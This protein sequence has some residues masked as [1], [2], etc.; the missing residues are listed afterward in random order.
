MTGQILQFLEK[1]PASGGRPHTGS[2]CRAWGVSPRSALSSTGSL[3]TTEA[4]ASSRWRL[5]FVCMVLALLAFYGRPLFAQDEHPPSQALAG[6][7]VAP[8]LEA[9][10]FASEPMMLSPT[11]IDVDARGRV[12]VCEV[13]NY[14]HRNGERPEGDRILILEDTDGDGRADKSTV[15]YQG[16]DIDSAMGI[17]VLGNRV[18][19]SVSPNVFV[20]TDTDGDGK[21]DKKELL[22]TKAGELQ[23][24]HTAHKFVFGPD[25]RLYWN[26]GNAEPSVYDRDGKVVKDIFGNPVIDGGHPFHGGMAFRCEP[27]GSR[28]EVLAHNFRNNY[29]LAVDSF[30]GL[31][32]SDND[33]DGN[34]AVRINYLL[35]YGNYG[36]RDEMTGA[37]WQTPRTN[38]EETIPERHWH[39][40]DPGVVPNLL[41][42]GAGSPTGIVAYEGTLLPKPFQGQAIHADAGPSI[43]RSYSIVPEA[44][45]YKSIETVN[46][47]SGTR[48]H[49]FRPSDV[50]VAPDGS[51]MVADWY[52]PGVG[53]H[54][55]GDIKR[56]RIYRLAPPKTPYRIPKHDF[57]SISG[58]IDALG[59]PNLETRYLAWTSLQARGAAAESALNRVY[60]ESTNPRLRARALWL[61]AMIDGRGSEYIARA[62]KDSDADLR[63]TAL[64]AA[65][66]IRS[67]VAKT[68]QTLIHDPSPHVRRECAIALRNVEGPERSKLWAELAVQ[69]DGRDRWFLEAL[70]IGAADDWDACLSA[71]LATAGARP[72][73]NKAGRDLVW[74]S[75]SSQTPALLETI[76]LSP[77][78]PPAE[79][80]R[81]LRAFDFQRGSTKQPV[82]A[83]LAFSEAQPGQVTGNLIRGEALARLDR[84][85]VV[86]N[87]EH[88]ATFKAF[89]DSQR[90]KPRLVDLLERFRVPGYSAD[91]LAV[92]QSHPQSNLGVRATRLLFDLGDRSPI[93]AALNSHDLKSIEETVAALSSSEDPR[94]AKVLWPVVDDAKRPLDIRR[95]AIRA[96]AR[97][98]RGADE[99]LLRAEQGRLDASL[100][101][102]ASASV[103]ASA[104]DA[105]RARAIKAF[106]LPP[107][108]DSRPLP[109]VRQ[110]LRR[111]GDA[112]K[113]E[114][115]FATIG[116]C[117]KCHVVN[118]QGKEVG[119]NLS[120]IGAKLS[121]PAIYE[122]ILFPS[123]GISHNFAA[124]T[125]VL[126]NGNAVSGILVS[127]TP[128]SIAIKGIDA[129]TRT[130]RMSEV[131]EIKEQS[132]SLM[133]ADLQKAMTADD[134]VNVVEYLTTL[135]ATSQKAVSAR[136]NGDKDK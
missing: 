15:F 75:R 43:V 14:R 27:D 61:L 104:S 36:Y 12:W 111:R 76:L 101:E 42:T 83:R 60:S 63:I 50:C 90:G 127:R 35:E 130:F 114:I 31:W 1:R 38:L 20:F 45:G 106:P 34:R 47:L 80:P 109:P 55:M 32:Q 6:L 94:A 23:H 95:Q 64:R 113:G 92:A 78:T 81:T 93:E 124:Y 74:R 108:L 30:G 105:I 25:G 59:S 136:V 67:D 98:R 54:R 48:D 119:P 97:S 118:G 21:A 69:H 134:L 96:L 88:V 89:L 39:Q 2:A 72:T 123:A 17:C 49:W 121:R 52:D 18:I 10:L 125:V 126:T 9:T 29:E 103:Y 82:L 58:A 26:M 128:D 71:W 13:V 85:D 117:A 84:N 11:N 16:R 33:D 70:G 107:A 24:D 110:L 37:G 131:E 133:P 66:R 53:G 115:V 116:T 77:N 62:A 129:I 56:G 122:S 7:D 3:P 22:F 8:G 120:E 91:L 132:V 28:F 40:N 41:V 100:R 102:A 112:R 65:R 5:A 87:P 57:N 19:V 46:L 51:L 68:V 73:S 4:P 99:V 86:N 79:M 135:K 44:A